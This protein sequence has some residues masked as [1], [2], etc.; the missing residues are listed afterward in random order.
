[1][2]VEKAILLLT[3]PH[4]SVQMYCNYIEM[5]KDTVIKKHKNDWLVGMVSFSNDFGKRKLV[6]ALWQ[7]PE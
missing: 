5:A 1:M 6:V 2:S 7:P 4:N 3:I